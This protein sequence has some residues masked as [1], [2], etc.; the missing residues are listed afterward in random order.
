MKMPQ[1]MRL[2]PCL[3]ALLLAFALLASI[4]SVVSAQNEDSCAD[5]A[6]PWA[7]AQIDDELRD[8]LRYETFTAPGLERDCETLLAARDTLDSSDINWSFDES[9]WEGIQHGDPAKFTS[10][11][12]TLGWKS[13]ASR[14]IRVVEVS[15]YFVNG[16]IPLDLGSLSALKSLFLA[17]DMTGPIPASLG[18]LSNLDELTLWGNLTGP[19]PPE[20]VSCPT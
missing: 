9:F 4:P 11:G 20:L 19:I 13:G 3:W 12:G 8:E 2:L 10:E 7:W 14:E 5:W 16:K 15:I 18:F 17:G 1:L 6:R